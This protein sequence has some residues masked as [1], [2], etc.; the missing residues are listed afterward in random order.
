MS[1]FE[2]VCVRA[3]TGQFS[4]IVVLVYRPGSATVQQTFFDELAAV[5]D[6]V[7]IYQEPK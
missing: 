6:R 4:A 7:A 1:T 5:L 2:M 3:V